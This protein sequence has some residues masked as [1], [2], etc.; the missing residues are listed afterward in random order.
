VSDERSVR[1]TVLDAALAVLSRDGIRAV[2][3]RAVA[4]EVGR[5]VRVVTYHFASIDALIEAAFHRY[6][7]RALA[8]F[9]AVAQSLGRH[10]T[11][12]AAAEALA[13]VVLMDVVGD[14]SGLL[15]EI[16]LVLEMAHR[17]ALEAVYRPWQARL[18]EMLT[19]QARA[20]GSAHAEAHA[21]I[22]LAALRGWELEALT[23]PSSPPDREAL[24]NQFERLIDGL[25]GR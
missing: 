2:T 22:I 4:A 6:V 15:L 5:S 10:T 3:H 25:Q 19:A 11:P 23:R 21:A 17:P 7:Q 13:D 12:R 8:R 9:D 1:E 24:A 16:A 18:E 20:L 14:R